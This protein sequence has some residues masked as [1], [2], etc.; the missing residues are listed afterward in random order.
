MTHPSPVD[1]RQPGTNVADR[2]EPLPV[3][4][5]FARV[6]EAGHPRGDRRDR[7]APG[8]GDRA[9]VAGV[10]ASGPVATVTAS[11]SRPTPP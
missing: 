11:A 4:V 10:V 2:K 6:G 7:D 5:D 1:G 3:P 8:G 9:G